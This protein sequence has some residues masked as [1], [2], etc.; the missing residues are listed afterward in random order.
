MGALSKT[1]EKA[2]RDRYETLMDLSPLGLKN[3]QQQNRRSNNAGASRLLSVLGGNRSRTNSANT[4]SQHD[5]NA[6]SAAQ[7]GSDDSFNTPNAAGEEDDGVNKRAYHY[8]THY[9]C[10]AVVIHYLVRLQPFS[11][12]SIALQ[13]GRF[14]RPDR[15]FRSI[16]ESWMSASGGVSD[17]PSTLTSNLQDVKELIPEFFFLPDFLCNINGYEMGFATIRKE[18]R[19]RSVSSDKLSVGNAEEA[20]SRSPASGNGQAV[21]RG[22]DVPLGVRVDDVEL[23]PWAHGSP[24]EFVRLHR[25]HG[26]DVCLLLLHCC[27]VI[28]FVL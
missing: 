26:H 11:S 17:D 1:R 13:A 7:G 24:K 3:K 15:L 6:L 12:H 18:S 27:N 9:S 14:D 19:T 4:S 20:P 25:Y 2:A 23:P 5:L 16:R 8:G 28:S 22:V 10:S 21:Q